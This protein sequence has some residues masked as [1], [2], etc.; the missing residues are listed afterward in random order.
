MPKNGYRKMDAEKWV[1]DRTLS[2]QV[3]RR[4]WARWVN[5]RND[6]Q[7]FLLASVAAPPEHKF[8]KKQVW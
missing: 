1:R 4:M 2:R 8:S 6:Y 7:W 3:S 5:I